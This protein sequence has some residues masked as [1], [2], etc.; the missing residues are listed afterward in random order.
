MEK[1]KQEIIAEQKAK[2][3]AA[4]SDSDDSDND[5]PAKQLVAAKTKPA[6]PKQDPYKYFM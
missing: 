2:I 3:K 1:R 6:K 4:I 5:V